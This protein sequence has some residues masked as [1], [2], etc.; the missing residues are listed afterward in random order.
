MGRSPIFIEYGVVRPRTSNRFEWFCEKATELGV[1]AITPIIEAFRKR[2]FKPS[3][4]E[5]LSSQP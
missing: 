5:R 2:F 3:V 1:D 4:A